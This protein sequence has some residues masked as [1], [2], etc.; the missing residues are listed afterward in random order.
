MAITTFYVQRRQTHY[1]YSAPYGIAPRSRLVMFIME[2]KR[3]C[4]SLMM[5]YVW[6]WMDGWWKCAD[7]GEYGRIGRASK[8]K[9]LFKLSSF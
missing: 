7:V 4:A 9:K 2:A 5:C 8:Q 1:V 3:M 6:K